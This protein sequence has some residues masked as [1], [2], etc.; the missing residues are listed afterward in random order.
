MPSR[1]SVLASSLAVTTAGCLSAVTGPNKTDD[2]L[3]TVEEPPSWLHQ[4]VDCYPKGSLELSGQTDSV[5]DST[6][7]ADYDDLSADSKLVV[8][9]AAQHGAAR[10]CVDAGA[11]AFGRLLGDLKDHATDPYRETHDERPLSIA[12]RA[13]GGDYPI[14]EMTAYDQVL[15]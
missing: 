12:I 3:P 13:G 9:F 15:V 1:R 11:T 5:N 14:D 6:A 7:V 8:R 2:E 10:T 4:D